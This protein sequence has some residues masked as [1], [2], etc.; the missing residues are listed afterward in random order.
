ML[1]AGT[2][3]HLQLDKVKSGIDNYYDFERKSGMENGKRSE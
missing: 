3:A 2:E 1:Y